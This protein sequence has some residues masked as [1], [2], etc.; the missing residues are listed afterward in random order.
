MQYELPTHRIAGDFPPALAAHGFA[1]REFALKAV[2]A[3]LRV[4]L[5]L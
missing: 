3:I 2:A 5:K 4:G 1:D